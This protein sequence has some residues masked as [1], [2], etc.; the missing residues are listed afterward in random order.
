MKYFVYLHGVQTAHVEGVSKD[1]IVKIAVNWKVI[2]RLEHIWRNKGGS[3]VMAMYDYNT[4]LELRTFTW[5][6]SGAY[7][8]VHVHNMHVRLLNPYMCTCTLPIYMLHPPHPNRSPTCSATQYHS[9]FLK[10]TCKYMHVHVSTCMC[11]HVH[12]WVSH[13]LEECAERCKTS[14]Y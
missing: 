1:R 14:Q 10:G 3:H 2:V 7:M 8:H 6:V 9:K 5:H 4:M 13:L 12:A 11:V